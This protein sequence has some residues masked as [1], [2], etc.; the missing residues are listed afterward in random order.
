MTDSARPSWQIHALALGLSLFCGLIVQAPHLFLHRAFVN[1]DF[2]VHYNYARETF[3]AM[4]A[5]DFW[6]HY[7]FRAQD[8]LGEPGLLY[9]AP[10][11]YMLTWLAA[12]AT[13]NVWSAMQLV[14]AASAGMLGYF[15]WRLAAGWS[16]PRRALAAVPLAV[17]APMACMLQLGFNGYPWASAL[18]PLAMLTWAVLRPEAQ[19]R[20]INLPAILA[21]ALTVVTH[22]VTGLMAV[23][24]LGA[25]G[26][27]ELLTG[28]FAAF[29]T[30]ALWA[31]ALT[32]AAGLLLS[33]A[34][35]LP[36]YG[37]QDLIDAGVWRQNYT[38]YNAFSLSTVTAWAFGVRWFAFQ[39]P[40]S[41]LA[42]ALAGLPLALFWRGRR[43]PAQRWFAAGAATVV[44]VILFLAT[45]LSYPLW[46]IDS[47]LRNI[48]FPHRLITVL[49]PLGAAL[50]PIAWD[51]AGGWMARSALALVALASLGMGGV[52]VIKAAV[53][54]GAV[55]DVS[56]RD[57]PTY[58]GLDE[59]RTKAAAE[60]GN[61]GNAYDF[62]A[63]CAERGLSC[64]AGRRSGR[65]MVWTVTSPQPG[66]LRLP[67]YCFPAWGLSV[68]GKAAAPRCDAALG[69][70]EV[71]L[72]AGRAD[73]SLQWQALPLQRLGLAISGVMALLLVLAAL[74]L[75]RGKTG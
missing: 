17:I 31:P 37:S 29:K 22:T 13:G 75:R 11:Y 48:Q 34:Y 55:I 59:Y 46:L 53:S 74:V 36:G 66:M 3:A 23:I 7:A 26:L 6:P 41:L 33:A 73:I 19:G 51:R 9:Y 28:R 65:G 64:S 63:A 49:V 45:E 57:F 8:G 52:A 70:V 43:H 1:L 32:G 58:A 14:E 2:T 5:G 35:L 72:P 24:L 56:E 67:V 71:A 47:P 54:D 21:L 10:L 62:A 18:G 27:A 12:Q 38:P 30:R 42:F 20:L 4:Q 25:L 60:H 16:D 68:N 61:R 50:V 44:A 15:A 40:V 69:L 39:W